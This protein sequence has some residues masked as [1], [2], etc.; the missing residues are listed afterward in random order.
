[1]TGRPSIAVVVVTR[2]RR[3]ELLATLRRLEG[4]PERPAIVVVDN[5]SRDGTTEAVTDAHPAV[6]LIRT[7]RDRGPSARN[8]GVAATDADLVAFND[9]DSVWEPGA[10]R[11]AAD[12]FAQHPRLALVAARVLVGPDRHL[13]PTCLAMAESPLPRAADLPGPSVLGFVAC[14]AVVRRSAFV[15]CGGFG[16]AFGFGGEETPL[17][18]V[19]RDAGWG[20][21]YVDTVVTRHHPSMARDPAARRRAVLDADLLLPWLRLPIDAALVETARVLRRSGDSRATGRA[22]L[23]LPTRVLRFRDERAPVS[24][25]VLAEWRTLGRGRPDA[26]RPAA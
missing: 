20:L 2:D 21:A 3:D 19:L 17:A 18:L 1:V 5:G 15:R 25:A 6:R 10:L 4:L 16:R 8:L 24:R 12:L 9:D 26:V 23:G 13:D 11:R 7:T 14:G 22:L